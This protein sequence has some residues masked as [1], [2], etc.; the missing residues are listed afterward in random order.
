[1]SKGKEELYFAT[2]RKASWWITRD[3]QRAIRAERSRDTIQEKE[4]GSRREPTKER[5]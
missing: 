1:M 3:R 4:Y 5:K 2:E